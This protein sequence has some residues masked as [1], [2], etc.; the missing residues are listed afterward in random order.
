MR[1]ELT[2]SVWRTDVLTINTNTAKI[3]PQDFHLWEQ[4]LDY[5]AHTVPTV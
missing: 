3:E 5:A 2:L 1:F 4:W